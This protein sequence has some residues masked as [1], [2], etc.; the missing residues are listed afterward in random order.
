MKKLLLKLLALTLAALMV[1]STTAC[2]G[3]G[4]KTD[5]ESTLEIYLLYKG[6]GDAWLTDTISR[7][8]NDPEVKAL[9][10]DLDVKYTFNSEDA[11][12]PQKIA[13]G[14]S[15][16][17]YD[18]MFGVNLQ[19]YESRGLI[20]DLTDSVYLAEVPGE[21]GVKVI[22]K[23]PQRVLEKVKRA[24]GAPVRQDGGDSY[25]V[26][27]YVDG[28]FGML[29][30]A[31]LLVQMDL[32]VPLTTLQF[33]NIGE[34]IKAKKY[35]SSLTANETTVIMNNAFDDY[36]RSAYTVWWAQYEGI[37]GV[38]D[39]FEG[40]DRAE[41]A[42]GSMTVLDQPGRLQSL[43]TVEDILEKYSYEKSQSVVDYK[44]AQGA[45]LSGRGVFH[46]N[47]DYFSTEM[48]LEAEALKKDG[49]DYDIKF[50]KMPVI[51]A[52]VETLSLYEDGKTDYDSLSADKKNY[53][54]AKLQV[55][56]ADVDADKT[57]DESTAKTQG[58]SKA[59]FEK[60]AEARM[61]SGLRTAVS[62][63]AVVPSYAKAKDLAAYFLRYMYKE[64]SIKQ[65]AVASEGLIFPA[66][67]DLSS[68]A[69]VLSK[70]TNI[71]KSK[72]GLLKG[73]TNYGFAPIPAAV[74]TTLGRGGLEA[75]RFDGKF[76]AMF[77]QTGDNRMTAEDILA[78]EKAHWEGGWEQMLSAAGFVG[79]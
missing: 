55:I 34:Q 16:N 75:I 47:G 10:P 78:A 19:G 70:F 71:N 31:D 26:V 6:Y 1:V 5:T 43:R 46:Y 77:R 2:F 23:V 60:V 52:I 44:E 17:T 76:E 30:N 73:T 50:M 56:I 42:Y 64:E 53:Y 21:A 63:A 13:A 18:L 11:H 39:Y 32:P 38:E 61:V 74:A 7:F 49:V 22:D 28:L 20:A 33:M 24:S 12:A 58:I 40:Y 72:V 65:Y 67:Y 57:Y 15:S 48:K 9:Y 41:D 25:Y 35:T 69:E 62:Q 36:W 79:N 59:D 45:F 3:G 68:D 29:Y 14:A 54:D 37:K 66:T 8:K 4:K 27:S 51:S